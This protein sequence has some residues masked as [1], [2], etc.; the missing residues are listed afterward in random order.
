M[1]NGSHAEHE[2]PKSSTVTGERDELSGD[3]RHTNESEKHRYVW[4]VCER[5]PDNDARGHCS[6]HRNINQ[7]RSRDSGAGCSCHASEQDVLR[8]SDSRNDH[9][10]HPHE[11]HPSG[12]FTVIIVP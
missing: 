4:G 1:M 3:E 11:Q 12:D 7:N 5:S 6:E 10:L 8:G 2:A 9:R